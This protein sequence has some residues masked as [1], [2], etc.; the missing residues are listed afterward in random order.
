VLE[1]ESPLR[2]KKAVA[3]PDPESDQDVPADVEEVIESLSR[4]PPATAFTCLF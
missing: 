1:A 2:G 4:P 3:A